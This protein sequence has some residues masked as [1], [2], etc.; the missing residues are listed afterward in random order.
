MQ[1]DRNSRILETSRGLVQ[2][3]AFIHQ[4]PGTKQAWNAPF[5]A[6]FKRVGPWI[7]KTPQFNAGVLWTMIVLLYLLLANRIPEKLGYRRAKG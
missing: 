2:A 3:T 6:P 1:T 4:M 5:Y 7:I